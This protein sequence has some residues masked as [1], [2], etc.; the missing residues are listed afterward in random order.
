MRGLVVLLVAVAI[1]MIGFGVVIPVM[2]FLLW[3]LGGDAAAQG[4]LVS[5]FSLFQLLSAPLW[6]GSCRQARQDSHSRLGVAP[7]GAGE[8]RRLFLQLAFFL[9]RWLEP[10]RASAA[11]P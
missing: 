11:G 4:F 5:L 2:P 8:R 9:W 3:E 6:G 1:H 7:L 10:W